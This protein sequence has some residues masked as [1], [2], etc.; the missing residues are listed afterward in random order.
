MNGTRRRRS[1]GARQQGDIEMDSAKRVGQPHFCRPG[2]VVH[3]WELPHQ[4]VLD[5]EHGIRI[6]IRAVVDEQVR[7]DRSISLGRGDEVNVG[8]P[9]GVST[10][11]SQQLPDGAVDGDRVVPR[12]DRPEPE[13][14]V[15]VG[16]EESSE[17]PLWL[18]T[19]LLN[20]VEAL[21]VGL[22]YVDERP[23]QRYAV[24]AWHLAGDKAWLT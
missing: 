24:R 15:V 23:S 10:G 16:G 17:V 22:P 11:R 18:H 3:A 13:P 12:D 8:G 21:G 14:A 20:I 6:E 7:G 2:R 9:V 4:T 19:G 5:T 1:F